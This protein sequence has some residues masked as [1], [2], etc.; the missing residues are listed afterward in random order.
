MPKYQNK[1]IARN[2]IPQEICA[3]YHERLARKFQINHQESRLVEFLNIIYID[4]YSN[5][6]NIITPLLL[7][8]N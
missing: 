4:I 2:A 1:A 7:E 3:E 6:S 8:R 5:V